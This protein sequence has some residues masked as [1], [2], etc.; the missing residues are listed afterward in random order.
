M[1]E[2]AQSILESFYDCESK[3]NTYRWR[4]NAASRVVHLAKPLP[5]GIFDSRDRAYCPLCGGGALPPSDE[6]FANPEGLRRH[7][8]GWG[9]Q[10]TQCFVFNAVEL[11]ARSYWSDKFHDQEQARLAELEKRR[12][13]ET[14]FKVDPDEPAK[15]IDEGMFWSK[16]RNNDE[17]IWAENRLATL[18]FETHV[19]ENLRSYTS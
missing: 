13:S 2:D 14:L 6:G 10:Q 1:P 8:I 18:G 11:G 9:G 7:L 3:N 12:K 17:L 4:D 15:L 16:P 19:K 5:K